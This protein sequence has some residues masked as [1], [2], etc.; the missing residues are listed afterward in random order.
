M[1]S[2]LFAALLL[3]PLPAAADD[4]TDA[5]GAAIEAYEDGD[6]AEALEEVAYATQLLNNLQA[7]GLTEFLPEP[8]P[9]GCAR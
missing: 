4:I 3:F 2:P 7:A 9:A 1:R 8:L 5:L 6:V